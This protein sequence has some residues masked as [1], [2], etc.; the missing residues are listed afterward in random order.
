MSSIKENRKI[1]VDLWKDNGMRSSSVTGDTY[2][3]TDKG[4]CY[5]NGSD[6]AVLA[7][8]VCP[9][10]GTHNVETAQMR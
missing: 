9:E 2:A 4:V 8:V 3:D 5:G 7:Y 10:S 6:N 1:N